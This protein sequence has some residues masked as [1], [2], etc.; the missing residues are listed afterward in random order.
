M[1]DERFSRVVATVRGAIADVL[2]EGFAAADPEASFVD[3][4]FDSISLARVAAR[5]SDALKID[6]VGPELFANPS[7]NAVS[8]FICSSQRTTE[9]T[10]GEVDDR[11]LPIGV[12]ERGNPLPLSFAQQRLWF[13]TRLEERASR[14]YHV[15]VALRL[16]GELDASA[17]RAALDRIVAR[18]ESLRTRFVAI[19]GVPQQQI[20]PC[21]VG[22]ALL[23]QDL[24]GA[25]RAQEQV[26]A[27]A[28]RE[29]SE[30]FDLAAGPLIRGR[31]LQV[32]DLEH[33]LLITLHHIVADAWSMGVL[34]R[35][36]T[37]LYGAY[38][39]GREDPMPRLGIQ[40]A[41]YALWQQHW[42]QGR[43]LRKQREYWQQRLAGAPAVLSLPTDRERPATQSYAGA[44][45]E[46]VLEEAL[47]GAL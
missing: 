30:D 29:A 40:Y 26:Q 7:V 44:S 35:E 47:S 36:L 2:G 22:F 1:S 28:A 45:V 42:L 13:V 34:F 15:A 23:Y 32:S 25:Q 5:L 4:G 9:E 39:E 11:Q 41:D 43:R 18:H 33:V 27:L 17:L 3:C 38:R 6:I 10:P 24:R 31:L 14:A 20:D 37:T 12:L 46:V 8:A 19:D 16:E 21:E